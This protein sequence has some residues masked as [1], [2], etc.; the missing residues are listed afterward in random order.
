MPVRFC[1]RCGT[2]T[3][4]GA[5]F[6]AECGADL[7]APRSAAGGWQL[8][9]TGSAVLVVFLAAGLVVWTVILS[10]AARPGL[11]GPAGRTSASGAPAT[12]AE[13]ANRVTLPDQAKAFIADLA[14]Q[15]KQ[16]PD[17]VDTWMKLAQV[18]ARAA[19]IDP[20]YQ[21]QAIN[22]YDHVLTLDPKNADALRGVANL[23]YDR[24][25]HQKAIPA[26]EKYLA[27]RPDDPSAKT[28]LG[29]MYLYSGQPERAVATYQD[30]IKK[31]PAFLQ[32]HYNLAVTYHGQGK[33][34]DALKE[35]EVARGLATDDTV[36]KQIDDMMVS[37]K[38]D[39]PAPAEPPAKT[40]GTGSPFQAAVEEAF[41]AHPIMGPRIVRFEWGAPASGRVLVRNFPM[42]GMPPEV[43]EK[44]TGRLAEQLRTAQAAHPVEGP[45]RIEIADA[46]DGSVMATVTP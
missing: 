3:V 45:V 21:T 41:R 12:A 27:L 28:D 42:A 40:A 39:R 6:C 2:K 29:T 5:K 31:N 9:I 18:T 19:Q 26:F 10:P 14:T 7:A 8:T 30:V 25:D 44:F 43:R 38:G 46:A 13:A 16:K 1:S 36:R 35:L 24:D 11:P 37:L 34:Q 4:A 23:H 20:A 33:D 32:A 17:D 22:A 15:A